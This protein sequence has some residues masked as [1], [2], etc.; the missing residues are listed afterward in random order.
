MKGYANPKLLVTP[1]ELA[2][3][4]D[5]RGSEAPAAAGP[6]SSR[7]LRGRAHPGRGAPRPLG[8]QPDRHRSGA[9]EGVHVDDRAPPRRP[10]RGGLDAGGRLRRSVRH[11]RRARVLVPRILRAS[12]RAAARRR[13]H[14][15]DRVGAA[16]LAR[17]RA[18][19]DERVDGQARGTQDCD[20]EGS[21]ERARPR[22]RGDPRHAHRR[23]IHGRGRPGAARRRGAGRRPHRVDAQPQRPKATSSRRRS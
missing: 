17:R 1:R 4:L 7:R 6:A 2:D 5:K 9:A 16:G 14:R 12:V 18:G 20:V 13:V 15:L 8:G 23:R 22:R 3:V 19:K 10:R 21:P 11:P